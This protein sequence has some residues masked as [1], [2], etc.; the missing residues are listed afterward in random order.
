MT[1]AIVPLYLDGQDDDG[2]AVTRLR[3]L[4]AQRQAGAITAL[5]F[6]RA[7]RAL[8][9]EVDRQCDRCAGSPAPFLHSRMTLCG[10]CYQAVR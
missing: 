8:N 6:D 7:Y 9:A 4:Q 5:E 2:D 10:R 3:A 1:T